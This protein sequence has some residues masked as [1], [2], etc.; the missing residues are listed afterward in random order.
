MVLEMFHVKHWTV[1]G[2]PCLDGGAVF[3]VKRAAAAR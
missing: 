2:R 3:H 1:A